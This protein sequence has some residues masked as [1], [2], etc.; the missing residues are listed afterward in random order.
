MGAFGRLQ[1]LAVAH[2]FEPWLT[3]ARNSQVLHLG[4]ASHSNIQHHHT[5]RILVYILYICHIVGGERTFEHWL[6]RVRN[7]QEVDFDGL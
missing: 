7:A 3:R 2:A 5:I 4:L 6:T 1:H